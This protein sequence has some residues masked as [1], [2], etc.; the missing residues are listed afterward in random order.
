MGK[1]SLPT[2]LYEIVSFIESSKLLLSLEDN[3][4]EEGADCITNDTWKNAVIFLINY[5]KF[6][7][8]NYGVSIK[9]PEIS[10]C[11]NGSIDLAWR[12]KNARLLLN[13]K[14]PN[15]PVFGSYYGDKYNNKDAIKNPIENN[16]V[17]DNLAFWMK[18][19]S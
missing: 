10:P 14:R 19:L 1:F 7:F 16:D 3:W 18:N 15:G 17:D 9:A 6:I 12:T 4:H 5:S 11:R 8:N 2:Q 13:I